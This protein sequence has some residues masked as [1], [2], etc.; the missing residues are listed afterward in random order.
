MKKLLI[1]VL[2]FTAVSSYAASADIGLKFEIDPLP[3]MEAGQFFSTFFHVYNNGPDTAEKIVIR[4]DAPGAKSLYVE[5]ASIVSM[6]AGN[7]ESVYVEVHGNGVRETI[8][9]TVSVSAD[10]PDPNAADNTLTRNIEF[11]RLPD[12]VV[13]LQQL[14]PAGDPEEPT[15]I[16]VRADN[17]GI[18]AADDVTLDVAFPAGTTNISVP[19][20][21]NCSVSGTNVHCSFG[22]LGPNAFSPPVTIHVTTPPL[23]DG[24]N[25]TFTAQVSSPTPDFDVHNNTVRGS[26]QILPF[27]VVSN[28]ND[29]GPGSLRQAIIDTGARCITDACRIGFRIPLDAGAGATIAPLSPLP[30][31]TGIVSSTARRKRP[32]PAGAMR[33]PS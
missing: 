33:V 6:P 25:P 14:T 23:Y 12:L 1:P 2:L 31:V 16:G 15:S 8:P 7:S 29:S 19:A 17:E 21:A 13:L 24:G 32:S 10:T 5:K 30:P 4:V 18:A 9:L 3:R 20:A 27:Y 11:V 28:T 26:W 22:T